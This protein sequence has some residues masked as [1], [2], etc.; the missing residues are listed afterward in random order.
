MWQSKALTERDLNIPTGQKT[1][2]T[3]SI[4]LDKGL[5]PEEEDHRPYF[6][7]KVFNALNWTYRLPTVDEA[8]AQFQ[9]I[10]KGVNYG[11]FDLAIRHTTSTTSKSYTPPR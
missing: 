4:N 2:K 6:R 11:M 5:L 7:N 10:L 9:F 1:N 3:G 8:Y